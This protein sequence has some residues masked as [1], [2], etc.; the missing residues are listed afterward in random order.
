MLRKSYARDTQETH[1]GRSDKSIRLTRHATT[2]VFDKSYDG[3]EREAIK[4]DA[5]K[6]AEM[7][8][9]IKRKKIS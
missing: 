7:F 9:F 5:R 4:N 8:S 1:G 2:D 3:A 6:V